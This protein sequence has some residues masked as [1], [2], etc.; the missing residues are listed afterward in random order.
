MQKFLYELWIIIYNSIQI[1][2]KLSIFCAH[3][4]N[5]WTHPKINMKKVIV[6]SQIKE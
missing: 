2:D 3:Q 5:Y 1:E 6:L 4:S